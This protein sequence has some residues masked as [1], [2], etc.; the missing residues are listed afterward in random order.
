MNNKASCCL[1][2]GILFLSLMSPFTIEPFVGA[3]GADLNQVTPKNPGSSLLQ[4]VN[5]DSTESIKP[6]PTKQGLP[7]QQA[8][9][10]IVPNQRMRQ[11]A[12]QNF[13]NKIQSKMFDKNMEKMHY[14][15]HQ[16]MKNRKERNT[17]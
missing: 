6:R 9:A 4:D 5:P 7:A 12:N 14:Q 13:N 17:V 8:T 1:L 3:Q 10:N 15:Y 16:R 2:L 11:I